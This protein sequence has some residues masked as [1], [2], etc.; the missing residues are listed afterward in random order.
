MN[1]KL[2][3]PTISLL[4]IFTALFILLLKDNSIPANATTIQKI[5]NENKPNKCY[6][7]EGNFFIKD[8]HDLYKISLEAIDVKEAAKK[9]EVITKKPIS[10]DLFL[11]L[12]TIAMLGYVLYRYS[13]NQNNSQRT[14]AEQTKNNDLILPI[15]SNTTFDDVA[16]VEEAK[17]EL[18]ELVDYLKN[19]AKYAK[20][21]IR[22]PRGV[23]LVGPPGVGKT[24]L[25]KALA[26]EAG[27]P[28]Y[29]K[30][31]ATFVEMYVGV[32]AKRVSDLF[33]AANKNS[34]AIIFIDE[35]DAIG[36]K[37][38]GERNEERES[39]LN[40]LL[41]EMDGFESSNGVLAIA[42]TNKPE[43]LDEAL[44][45]ANRFDRKVYVDLPDISGRYDLFKLYLKGKT[46]SANLNELAKSSVGFSGAMISSMVNEAALHAMRERKQEITGDDFKAVAGKVIDGKKRVLVLDNTQRELLALGQAAKF[47]LSKDLGVT[48]E[49]LSL[50][51]CR[52]VPKNEE[53]MSEKEFLDLT[54]FYISP[55]LILEE[56]YGDKYALFWQDEKKA[57]HNTELAK[58][59]YMLFDGIEAEAVLKVAEAR[60]KEL[61][62][63]RLKE[64]QIIKDKLLN[65]QKI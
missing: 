63:T 33:L 49:H 21:G 50:S 61:L 28:F 46:Y 64:L 48:I 19:P 54:A 5:L 18:F 59:K 39:T 47:V 11:L 43:V 57:L 36:R 3:V 16:G 37:R 13:Q 45:R 2:F 31:A 1:K 25:A 6:I 42:A 44:L 26:N 52:I 27:I 30:S 55:N 15:S 10:A 14:T 29:Y 4:V 23:L 17:E 65:E 51:E 41:T 20:I 35:I 34:P 8:T 7:E 9:C 62:S 56:R 60:A 38:S 22:M 12:I 32:G 40:Q 24:L 53:F 58:T